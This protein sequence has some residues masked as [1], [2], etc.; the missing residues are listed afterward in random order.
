LT[1]RDEILQDQLDH[2]P[3]G[4]RRF[5]DAAS[6]V[7]VGVTGTGD[8]L[9]V[10]AWSADDL[11]R[12]RAAGA[13]VLAHLGVRPGMR[14]ANALPGALATPGSLLLGDVIEDIGALDV[15]LGSIDSEAAARQAWD[16]VDRVQPEML[17]LDAGSAASLFAGVPNG[18]RS[19]WQG[20]VWVRTDTAVPAA[21]ALPP[22]AGFAGWQRTWVAIPEATCFAAY[23]CAALRFHVDDGI[24]AEIAD[25]TT[26]AV[27]PAGR[28]GTLVVTPFGFDTPLLRYISAMQARTVSACTCGEAGTVLELT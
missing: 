12:E 14:V 22:D 16:L 2:L 11:R 8:S 13:R 9:L 6:P 3:H 7:R 10:L 23:S 15:P 21:A 26:G 18:Q 5:A 28:A 19:W 1:R 20:I 25:L 4:T 17:I 24:V 27:A